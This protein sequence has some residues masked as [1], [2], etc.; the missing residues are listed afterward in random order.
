MTKD[1]ISK[2]RL[3]H[4]KIRREWAALDKRKLRLEGI[5][6]DLSEKYFLEPKT[7]YNIVMRIGS[8][9]S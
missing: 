7:I 4:E 5:L 6:D 3:R 1:K 2:A 9:K 8:Y